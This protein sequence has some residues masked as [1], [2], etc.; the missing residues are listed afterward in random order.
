[1]IALDACVKHTFFI[2]PNMGT[3]KRRERQAC[4]RAKKAAFWERLEDN[5]IDF[6]LPRSPIE[7]KPA[8]MRSLFLDICR[9]GVAH[10]Y[11]PQL[12]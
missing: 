11:N 10:Q 12:T 3:P 2:A 8:K 6:S 1:M 7:A 4:E 5:T 9:R